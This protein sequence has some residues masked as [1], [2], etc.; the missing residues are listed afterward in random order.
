LLL[1]R[2]ASPTLYPARAARAAAGMSQ[3]VAVPMKNRE[4]PR[5]LWWRILA[6]RPFGIT[7]A[8]L[9]VYT[10]GGFFL[11]PYL[12]QRYTPKIVLEQL[13]RRATIGEVRINPFL[14][15][16]EAADASLAEADGTP[17]LGFKRLFVDFELSSLLRWA[18]VFREF[19]LSRPRV[20]VV[21]DP[22]GSVNLT[23]LAP[24]ADPNDGA[25]DGG[26][27]RLVLQNIDIAEGEIDVTDRRQSTHARVRLLPLNLHLKDISTLPEREG[28]Y[29][30]A[31]TTANGES[32]RWRGEVTLQPLRS[33]G[34]LVFED[35]RV[36]T[37]WEFGRD[38][39]AIEPPE[40]KLRCAVSYRL[41]LGGDSPQLV[42]DDLN[43]E[44]LGL[45]LK[46]PDE[47]LPL[48]A[49]ERIAI[50][51]AHLNLADRY[52]AI[53]EMHLSDGRVRLAMDA[54]GSFN[55]LRLR[56][57]PLQGA[58]SEVPTAQ[59]LLPDAPRQSTDPAWSV[60]AR[61]V[62]VNAVAVDYS[63]QSRIPELDAGT[64]DLDARFNARIAAGKRGNF[65]RLENVHTRLT[66]LWLGLL[67]TRDPAV[68]VAQVNFENGVIDT[69]QRAAT[70]SRIAAVG[71]QVSAIRTID[72]EIDLVQL[73]APPRQG[74]VKAQITQAVEK[75]EPW[76]FSA[77]TVELSGFSSRFADLTVSADGPL[78]A[79]EGLA[80]RLKTVDLKSPMAFEAETAV[81]GGGRVA[82]SGTVQPADWSAETRVT[83][84]AVALAGI[85]PYIDRV[86]ALQLR[87]GAV[88]T[89]G[90]LRYGIRGAG[91]DL[92]YDGRFNLSNLRITLPDSDETVIGWADLKTTRLHLQIKPNRLRIGELKLLRPDGT[93]IVEADATINL[94]NVLKEPA[95]AGRATETRPVA[96]DTTGEAFPVRIGNL[97]VE[98]G[99]L[100]FADRSLPIPFA[101]RIHALDGAL[102]GVSSAPQA[103]ARVQLRG[104]VNEYG[105]VQISGAV[106]A[107]DPTGFL[108]MAMDFRNLEMNR[109]T[110]YSGK[111]A[112]R[113]IDSGK[114]SLDLKYRIDDRSLV[115][116]H[117]IV[118]DR[119]ALGQK[120]DSPDAVSLPLDLAVALLEDAE[121]RIDIGLPIKGNLDDPQFSYGHLLWQA[122]ANLITKVVAAP[123]NALAGLLGLKGQDL[124]TLAFEPGRK[125]L[126]PPEREKL[127]DLAD[128]MQQRP[129]LQ[130]TVQGRFSPEADAAALKALGLRRALA[131]RLGTEPGPDEDPGPVD[132]A[133]PDVHDALK[134]MFAERFG[135]DA[136]KAPAGKASAEPEDPD[137]VA[138]DR[139][140]RLAAV[141]PLPSEALVR[142][143]EER[144]A[145][146]AGELVGSGLLAADRLEV[147][148]PEALPPKAPV[149]VTLNLEVSKKK[150]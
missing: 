114:L 111:F 133:N 89:Q 44:L 101:V 88:S 26:L 106:N 5:P 10:L 79:L 128:A 14:F 22:D 130:L 38:A 105:Q 122:L 3:E 41:D 4:N 144:A 147:L 80:V 70:F 21:I 131:T 19:N 62:A 50:D 52:L 53:G 123:F 127:K 149:A 124:S 136:L 35:I 90:T 116:D 27:P 129:Q 16:L 91:A 98:D 39:L 43:V 55:L 45:V 81:K 96:P 66:D 25:A 75:G 65:V 72:G 86:A 84:D 85:Q 51:K 139:F 24:P 138:R 18:W 32:M 135:A 49:L 143:A 58:P 148:A 17:L 76:G 71:G 112:G 29:R 61:S 57:R 13:Q 12:V 77:D 60:D 95:P 110:P 150:T 6:G 120:V 23:R 40:G 1:R 117:R 121:G 99:R 113:K 142:L 97:R 64:Q 31:A 37:L 108:D 87:S 103:R 141:E 109:L 107:F 69:D 30:L 8:L 2:R 93:L 134:R 20:D 83:V 146:V 59:P 137:E 126:P 92:V 9:L 104:E 118:V 132:F 11:A 74:A 119:L 140:D 100:N 63:D 68:A 33:N 73:L 125:D 82:L 36:E 47:P 145:A 67:G 34:S 94:A 46:L 54:G 28:P 56:R 115:G 42:L 48:V 7:V 78:V 15:T 102:S